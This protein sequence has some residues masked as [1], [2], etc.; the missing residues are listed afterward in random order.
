MVMRSQEQNM[1]INSRLFWGAI[2]LVPLPLLVSYFMGLWRLEHYQYFP[3]LLFSFAYLIFLRWDREV[4]PPSGMLGYGLLIAGFACLCFGAY[5]GS[6]WLA[7]VSYSLIW[8]S[9]LASQN[10]TDS[11]RWGLLALWPLTWM[12]IRLPL[13][14][15]IHLMGKLQ[16]LTSNVGSTVLNLLDIPHRLNGNVFSLAKGDLFIE[17]ACSGVQSFFTLL[18]CAFLLV[19]WLQRSVALL[20]IYAIFA[21]FWAAVLNVLRIVSIAIAQEKLGL[22]LA[23][24]WYHAV[25]GYLC[26]VIALLLFLSSDRLLRVFFFPT[27]VDKDAYN[28]LSNFW[29]VLFH[30][31]A[32]V[33]PKTVDMPLER[34]AN[35]PMKRI[36]VIFAGCALLIVGTLE[37]QW[38]VGSYRT[39]TKPA[40]TKDLV[41]FKATENLLDSLSSETFVI[42]KFEQNRSKDDVQLGMNSDIWYVVIDGV[43]ARIAVSQSYREFHDLC[44]CY[45]A[46]GWKVNSRLVKTPD[47]QDGEV[48]WSYVTSSL[49]HRDGSQGYLVFSGLDQ[50][51]EP[52]V[53]MDASLNGLLGARMKMEFLDCLMIQTWVSTKSPITPTQIHEINLVHIKIRDLVRNQLLAQLNAAS[54]Q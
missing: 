44:D 45:D 10:S 54:G 7:A 48:P 53:P 19:A 26:L 29:N 38:L 30:H 52:E 11:A 40:L 14:L 24:G 35:V 22:N 16:R 9:W 4:R 42:T 21:V 2:F 36:A 50:N 17:E 43:P 39:D 25:L 37:A 12:W 33:D 6:P 47:A 18:F 51:G 31:Q 23:T 3:I 15:D 27:R 13:N 20:P 32:G 49:L 5:H 34:L 46:I 1:G 41:F 8:G 28:P